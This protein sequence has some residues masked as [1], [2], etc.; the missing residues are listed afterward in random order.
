MACDWSFP[1]VLPGI[2]L[3]VDRSLREESSACCLMERSRG[4]NPAKISRKSVGVVLNAPVMSRS[5]DLCT[6][7]SFLRREQLLSSRCIHTTEPCL[8]PG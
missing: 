5:A 4:S 2:Q 1:T 7:V 8:I 6:W 3:C